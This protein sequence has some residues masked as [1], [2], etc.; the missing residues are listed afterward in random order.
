[1][2]LQ[3]PTEKKKNAPL[4]GLPQQAKPWRGHSPLQTSPAPLEKGIKM[5]NMQFFTVIVVK[6]MQLRVYE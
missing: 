5:Q 1:M 6:R 3:H 4:V 2:F